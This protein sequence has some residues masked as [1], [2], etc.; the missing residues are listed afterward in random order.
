MLTFNAQCK[1][2]SAL[3]NPP[4]LLS[5]NMG[6]VRCWLRVRRALLSHHLRVTIGLQSH[7]CILSCPRPLNYSM[8]P[9]ITFLFSVCCGL[10]VSVRGTCLCVSACLCVRIHVEAIKSAPF[11]M[12]LN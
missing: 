4:T 10:S 2:S 12:N 7:S 9:R 5:T 3:L 11:S 6:K 1:A 8:Q